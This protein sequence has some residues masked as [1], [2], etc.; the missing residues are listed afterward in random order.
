[1]LPALALIEA[2]SIARGMV[3]SDRC[4]KKAPI[5][6][7]KSEPVSPGKFLTL[8]CGDVASVEE[9]FNEGIQTAGTTL[10]DRLY[11]PGVHDDLLL[12]LTRPASS[13]MSEI[14]SLGIVETYTVAACLCAADAALKAADCQLLEMRLGAGLGGKG[15]FVLSGRLDSIEASVES[16]RKVLTTEQLTAVE[17]VARPDPDYSSFQYGR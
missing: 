2:A 13:P 14:D 7:L 3:I 5:V 15:Y 1:M 16:A 17:I 10:V 9:A 4:C 8:F 11:L 12:R 6:L